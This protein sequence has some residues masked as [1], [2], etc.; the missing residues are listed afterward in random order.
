MCRALVCL[1]LLT[2]GAQTPAPPE[3]KVKVMHGTIARVS[4]DTGLLVIK[5]GDDKNFRQETFQVDKITKFWAANPDLEE[6]MARILAT[7]LTVKSAKCP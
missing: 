2:A 3:M 4:A 1:T 5:M 7:V 6:Y